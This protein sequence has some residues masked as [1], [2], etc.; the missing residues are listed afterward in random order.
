MNKTIDVIK[1]RYLKKLIN[2]K[3]YYLKRT[4][5]MEAKIYEWKSYY[6]KATT[7][8]ERAYCNKMIKMYL[9]RLIYYI[10]K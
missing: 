9:K 10:Y 3:E 7:N 5:L 1:S 2:D 4:D 8:T 6:N